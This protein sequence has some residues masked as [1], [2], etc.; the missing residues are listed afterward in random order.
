MVALSKHWD[1]IGDDYSLLANLLELADRR[2]A[3]LEAN[4]PLEN[5]PAPELIT[6]VLLTLILTSMRRLYSEEWSGGHTSIALLRW[7]SSGGAPVVH[8]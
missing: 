1:V 8:C 7:H 6:L 2:V 4:S 3:A 5:V